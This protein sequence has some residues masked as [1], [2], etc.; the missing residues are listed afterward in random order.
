MT[1]RQDHPLIGLPHPFDKL[2]P[3]MYVAELLGTALL[4]A[5]GL[6][7]VIAL[8]GHGSP[9]AALPLQ[10][11]LRRL[12]NGALFGGTGAVIAY[13][14]I[15]RI[16]GA[17]INPAMTLA[18]WLEGKIA[19]R[20]ALGYVVA[21]LIGGALGAAALLFWGRIGASTTYGA[22][23]PEMDVPIFWPV[24]GEVLCTYLLVLIV[25]A[26]VASARLRPYTPLSNPVLFA[27]L[28][29]LEA[30]LSGASANPARS[31]G[32]ALVSCTWHG[33]WVYIAG[34]C[35]GAALA[36]WTL[37]QHDWLHRHR[38]MEA[39]LFHFRHPARTA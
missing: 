34:P 30:P 17:H 12:L 19:W 4:V 11:G 25:F 37:R 7:V 22:S 20:D 26:M 38:P 9:L 28:V 16:S 6:S 23:L 15:G 27:I 36:V 10:P 3:D 35:L 31:F 33:F 29:W 14:A 24:A 39:R 8:W 18:F 1:E 5:V 32:P 2:H 21:Q 13:S